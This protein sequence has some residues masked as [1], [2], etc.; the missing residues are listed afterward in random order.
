MPNTKN[1]PNEGVREERRNGKER[2][3]NIWIKKENNTEARD[4]LH[5][6]VTE[7]WGRDKHKR[8]CKAHP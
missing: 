6:P 4:K 8:A 1:M 7:G 2:R 5:V 3:R